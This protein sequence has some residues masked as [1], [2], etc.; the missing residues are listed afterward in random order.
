[1]YK[2]V[3]ANSWL[4]MGK[5]LQLSK[6]LLVGAENNKLNWVIKC[7]IQWKIIHYSGREIK[8]QKVSMSGCVTK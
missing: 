4:M 2:S 7:F 1:M 8:E 6:L 5:I 3:K